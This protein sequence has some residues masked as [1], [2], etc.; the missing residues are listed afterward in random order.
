MND[1]NSIFQKEKSSRVEELSKRI[2]FDIPVEEVTLPSE[3]KLYPSDH[4]FH[5]VKGVAIRS[6]TAREEDLLTSSA[7]LKAGTV[8]DKLIESCLINKSVKADSLLSG[9]RNALLVAIRVVGYGSE[10][11]VKVKCPECDEQFE[12]PFVL[13]ELKVKRLNA[14]PVVQGKNEFEYVLPLSKLRVHFK[15]LTGAD[16]KIISQSDERKRK[17]TGLMETRVT[18]RLLHSIVSIN[19]EEDR[20]KL[21]MIVSN[22]RA[23]DSRALRSYMDKVEPQLEMIQSCKCQQCGE[24]SEVDVPIGASFFFPTFD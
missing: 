10:Y 19:G 13:N 1:E 11:K 4:A 23:G 24:E 16:E 12:H 20:S 17:V 5:N 9:D 7:L 18:N 6:M 14:E 15:L 3:G 8:I 22:L 21:S 2:G